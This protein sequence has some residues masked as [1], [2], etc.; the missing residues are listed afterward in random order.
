MRMWCDYICSFSC[1]ETLQSG[2]V[3]G[4]INGICLQGFTYNNEF[5]KNFIIIADEL[6]IY[7][8]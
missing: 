8:K 2:F 1:V 3:G 5:L 4:V 7:Y 6:Y